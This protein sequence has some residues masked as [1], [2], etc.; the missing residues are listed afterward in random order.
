MKAAIVTAGGRIGQIFE[1][2]MPK[3]YCFVPADCLLSEGNT[4][5]V[6]EGDYMRSGWDVRNMRFNDAGEGQHLFPNTLR[7]VSDLENERVRT[8]LHRIELIRAV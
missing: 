8:F 4:L 7:P 5:R 3:T 2:E 1:G 6:V